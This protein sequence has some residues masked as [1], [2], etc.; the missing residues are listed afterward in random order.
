MRRFLLGKFKAAIEVYNEASRAAKE[1]RDVLFNLGLCYRQLKLYD[2]AIKCFKEAND[3]SKNE[4]TFQQI[5]RTYSVQ[6][7]LQNAVATYLDALQFSNDNEELLS[8]MGLL[9]LRLGEP[10]KAFN[11]LERALARNP[12]DPKVILA[13]GSII[14][15]RNEMD[16]ALLKY[17]IAA[18]KTP[19]SPQLWNNI[20]AFACV[21]R[22]V[23]ERRFGGLRRMDWL[24]AVC[25]RGFVFAQPGWQR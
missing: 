1:D 11:Y 6:E 25:V 5:G 22:A 23:H 12:G 15:D 3:I 10:A 24:H 4:E 16:K 17:R 13:A 19:H 7:D 21:S 14:Q 18:V 20:G 9:Y 8:A 2:K